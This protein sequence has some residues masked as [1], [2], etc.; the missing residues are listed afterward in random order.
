MRDMAQAN[1]LKRAYENMIKFENERKLDKEQ[2]EKRQKLLSDSKK[3]IIVKNFQQAENIRTDAKALKQAK[4]FHKQL[5]QLTNKEQ[6]DD[7]VY[8]YT[9]QLAD[10]NNRIED[11]E[12][13]ETHMLE[14]LQKSINEHN[15]LLS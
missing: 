14:N 4:F 12:R 10:M 9:S 1:K 2:K 5:K 3:A 7:K 6:K 11:L 13:S 15:R 8:E